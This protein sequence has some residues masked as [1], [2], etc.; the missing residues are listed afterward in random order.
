MQRVVIDEPYEFV[1]P[2]RG[3]W[4]PRFLLKLAPMQLRRS[5]GVHETRCSGLEKL[6]A[7]VSAGHGVVLAPNHCRLSDPS[8][9]G[10]L[11]RQ[12]GVLPQMMASWHLFKEGWLQHFVLRRVG[13]FSVYREGTDRQS[14][15]A[16]VE[17]LVD[18]TRP[19]VI[20]PEGVVT[21][22]NDRLITLMDGLS[23][24][25]RSAA[26]KRAKANPGSKVVVHPVAIRYTFD[27]DLESS[28]HATLDDIEERLSWRPSRG[29]SLRSRIRRVGEALL[30][31]KEIEYF[32]HP[33]LG[34]IDDRLGKL[35]DRILIPI[36]CQWLGESNVAAGDNVVARVKAL[37]AVMVPKL[38]EG[39]LSEEDKRKCWDQL[40]GMYIAQQLGHYPPDYISDN[41]TRERLLETVERMEE[42]LTDKCRI[43]GRLIA[44][45]QVGDAIEVSTQRNRGG[46]DLVMSQLES[47]LHDLLGIHKVV[48]VQP[49]P[50]EIKELEEAT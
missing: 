14:V 36:E 47:Q 40:A 2:H 11:C 45:V 48:P 49:P 4:W 23:L 35:I 10:E 38:I 34:E 44:N 27:G 28:L 39:D 30:W 33:Q 12:A 22:T 19:L 31:L 6:Q 13:A 32:G 41:P 17:T 26:K 15:N 9:V 3:M 42:D 43:H 18:A 1:P 21:R 29:G 50:V 20:F 24:I 7:S 37:R 25:T 8:V 16:A 46:E 5:Y